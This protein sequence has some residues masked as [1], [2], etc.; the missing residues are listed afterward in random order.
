MNESF[1]HYLWQFQYFDKK[2]LKTTEGE[3]IVIYKQGILNSHAG[4]DFSNA[5]IKIG[6]IEWAGNVE[7]HIKASGWIDHRHQEDAAYDNVILHVVWQN[8]KPIYARDKSVLPTLELQ[9]RAPGALI[10]QYQKLINT[11]SSVPCERL[12]PLVPEITRFSMSDRTLVER[13]QQK[14]QWIRDLYKSIGNDW[15][16]TAYQVIAKN[17]GFKVNNDPFLA[18]AQH[19][20]YKLILK[21]S[22]PIQVEALIFGVAGFLEAGMKDGYFNELQR[23]FR[24]QKTKYRLEDKV[25]NPAQWRFLRLRP[26]NFPTIRLA[27]FSAL[28]TTG[29]NLFSR[30]IEAEGYEALTKLFSTSQSAYWQNH[31]RFGKKSNSGIS[32]MGSASVDNIIINSVAPLLVAYGAEKGAQTYIEWAQEILQQ[33]P[34]ESNAITRTWEKL[35]WEVKTAFDSQALIGLYSNYCKPKNCLNCAVGASILKPN[36]ER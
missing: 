10:T 26:A 14:S 9:H 20:P 6:T 33:I 36:I 15:E 19:L 28:L 13:L 18:L 16:E 1:L 8:D 7:I 21:Q 25:L 23:E 4:P 29:R 30:I 31:Y 2:E 11:T 34:A 35:N 22:N 5:K 3:D 12:L 27:Q 24:L 32:A 17:F